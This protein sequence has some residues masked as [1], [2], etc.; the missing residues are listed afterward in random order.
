MVGLCG[1][2]GGELV[3]MCE[4]QFELECGIGRVVFGSAGGKGF[5]I[6]GQRQRIDG[7]EDEKVIVRSADTRA[8]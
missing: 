3:A 5:T 7:K 2:S 6:P 1:V 8:L 4:E